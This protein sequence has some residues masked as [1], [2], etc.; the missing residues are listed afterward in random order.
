MLIC[1]TTAD[2]H[3]TARV[4]FPMITCP[5]SPD[6]CQAAR[7]NDDH[8]LRPLAVL[9]PSRLLWASVVELHSF[10]DVHIPSARKQTETPTERWVL[11]LIRLTGEEKRTMRQTCVFF[12]SRSGAG[13]DH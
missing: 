6:S 9:T 2:V 8:Q 4:S 5:F 7:D 12:L 1:P 10:R 11:K 3:C 13:L